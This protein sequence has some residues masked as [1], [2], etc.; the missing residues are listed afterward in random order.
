MYRY[1][2]CPER[3]RS[4]TESFLTTSVGRI[5]LC[6]HTVQMA[7]AFILFKTLTGLI[8][9]GNN[10]SGLSSFLSDKCKMDL[11]VPTVGDVVSI[12]ST[13]SSRRS[14]SP[15]SSP[16]SEFQSSAH[17][18]RHP[19]SH[20]VKSKQQT[21]CGPGHRSRSTGGSH[22]APDRTGFFWRRAHRSSDRAK[23]TLKFIM[24]R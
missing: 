18:R 4:T 22:R 14:Q 7:S 21:G 3:N 10:Q 12:R 19:W 23:K 1:S 24:N 17:R 9:S 11:A 2:L 8:P 13:S 16:D 6:L 15:S 5:S 20:L